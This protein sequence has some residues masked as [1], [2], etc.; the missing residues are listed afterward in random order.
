MSH[1]GFKTR[2]EARAYYLEHR[3]HMRAQQKARRDALRAAGLCTSCGFKKKPGDEHVRC[4]YCRL[5]W[6]VWNDDRKQFGPS[7]P[8]ERVT[9]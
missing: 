8:Y 1:G 6:R 5:R 3:E 4:D 7:R 2:E 9:E